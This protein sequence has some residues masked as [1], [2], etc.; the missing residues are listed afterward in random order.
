M[1]SYLVA[2]MAAELGCR[3]EIDADELEALERLHDRQFVSSYFDVKINTAPKV[4]L[5]NFDC[6]EHAIIRSLRMSNIAA[7]LN[8]LKTGLK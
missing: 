6:M 4:G 3:Y 2:K 1:G 8:A 5:M 7:R